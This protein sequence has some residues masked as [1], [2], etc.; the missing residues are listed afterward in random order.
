MQLF[1]K[2]SAKLQRMICQKCDLLLT[3]EQLLAGSSNECFI[4]AGP[5]VAML[6]LQWPW[7]CCPPHHCLACPRSSSCQN[8]PQMGPVSSH[9]INIQPVVT[10]IHYIKWSQGKPSEKFSYVLYC[11]S[12]M[13]RNRYKYLLN[14]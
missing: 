11:R 9:V 5:N 14:S 1:W 2:V 13:I 10:F 6:C 8:P 3:A 7:A 4:C 12:F